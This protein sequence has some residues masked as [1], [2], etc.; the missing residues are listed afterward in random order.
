M[1]NG[2]NVTAQ[3]YENRIPDEYI[4]GNSQFVA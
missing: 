3:L 4:L 2:Y 1:A